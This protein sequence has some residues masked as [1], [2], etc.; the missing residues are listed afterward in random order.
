MR[1]Q[2]YDEQEKEPE[3]IV[4]LKLRQDSDDGSNSVTL[5]AVDSEGCWMKSLLKVSFDGIVRYKGAAI[6]N[7]LPTDE[8]GHVK[9]TDE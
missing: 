7:G 9:F 5:I 3:T 2:V 4:R 6:P 1:I 8:A